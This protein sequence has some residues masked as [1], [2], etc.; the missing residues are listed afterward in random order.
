MNGLFLLMIMPSTK[1][2]LSLSFSLS[3]SF[4]ALM[5]GSMGRK[6]RKLILVKF[7][8]HRRH[9]SWARRLDSNLIRNRFG[10]TVMCCRRC[11]C[12]KYN[13]NVIIR[14]GR[15]L[16]CTN[17]DVCLTCTMLGSVTVLFLI[18]FIS[19]FFAL[20]SSLSSFAH[21]FES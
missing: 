1:S 7:S 2:P 3:F 18:N 21:S 5:I 10:I 13:K 8:L 16:L 15:E 17:Q 20:F 11:C 14:A 6:Q 9:V 4:F 12:F 19:L